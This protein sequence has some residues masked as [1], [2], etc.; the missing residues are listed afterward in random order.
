[1]ADSSYQK[2]CFLD[3]VLDNYY[4]FR[5]PDG[6]NNNL[7]HPTYGKTDQ[8]FARLA[9]PAYADGHNSP[10]GPNRPNTRV[11][12]NAIFE[13][14]KS[15]PDPH[16]LSNMFWLWGQFI[17]HT[18]TLTETG[19]EKL[20]ISVPKGDAHF[21]PMGTGNQTIAFTRS[22]Y[23]GG[24]HKPREQI[25]SLTPLLDASMVYGHNKE[26]SDY[27]RSFKNGLLRTSEGNLLPLYDGHL[28]NAG[29][30]KFG[31]F[32]GGDVRCNEHSGLTSLHTLFVREHNYWARQLR[33][34]NCC[35]SDEQLYQKVRVIVEAEIQAITWYE[36]LPLL[37][38]VKQLKAY[39]GFDE[40]VDPQLSNTF[41][42]AAYRFGHSMI[43][44]DMFNGKK[45]LRDVFFA[46]HR[47]CN[48]GGIDPILEAFLHTHAQKL[49]AKLIDD[50]R[51]FLFGPPGA[52]GH[53]LVALNI[54]R[55]RDHG[56]PDYKSL[57]IILG[58]PNSNIYELLSNGD[59]ALEA[60]LH[61][62]YQNDTDID[63]FVA[64]L[65]EPVVAGSLVGPLF[66]KILQVQ[67]HKMRDGD[68]F[69]FENRMN[70]KEQCFIRQQTLSHIIKRNSG[71]CRVNPY[72][73]HTKCQ[74]RK[75][76]RDKKD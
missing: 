41:S 53:D 19:S 44:G 11:V 50:L 74:C 61:Q 51:N 21:D 43:S 48:E 30:S 37:L 38:G 46:S 36:F 20:L 15:I 45:R 31:S 34:R 73:F 60:Q 4:E 40:D 62:Y 65:L 47:I 71:L 14:T 72:V 18:F 49:N 70:S 28:A 23:T 32:I 27:L 8:P 17:D 25:N 56:L 35:L 76:R 58:L 67:F 10:A 9:P 66:H 57:L 1:M 29:P 7:K 54:Q 6:S 64:G 16:D 75:C 52:G 5:K 39:G 59:L 3:D 33:K 12:S 13:Q 68:R 22:K 63:V 55:G 24:S 2:H 42:T 69:W 26:R